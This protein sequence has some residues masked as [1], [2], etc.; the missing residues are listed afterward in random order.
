[1]L[2]L[3][4]IYILLE[5]NLYRNPISEKES[6]L[7]VKKRKGGILKRY[8]GRVGTC[9][10]F[11]YSFSTPRTHTTCFLTFTFTF[12]SFDACI[13]ANRSM[14]F[15]SPTPISIGTIH[16]FILFMQYL[17]EVYDSLDIF[18]RISRRY[19]NVHSYF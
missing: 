12:I 18:N 15:P 7:T 14:R 19:L 6:T 10:S 13:H 3:F 16:I 1:M 17:I 11:I 2:L 9:W 8:T 5:L 4:I